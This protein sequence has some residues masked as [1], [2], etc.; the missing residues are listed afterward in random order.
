MHSAAKAEFEVQK[1]EKLVCTVRTHKHARP[2][3]LPG[4]LH[5]TYCV[6]KS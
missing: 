1:V 4:P 2:T 6:G 3:A 5:S